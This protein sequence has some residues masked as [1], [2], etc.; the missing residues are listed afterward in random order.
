MKL[1][2]ES[3]I[4]LKSL[5]VEQAKQYVEDYKDAFISKVKYSAPR[6]NPTNFSAY[7]EIISPVNGS[8][9][10]ATLDYCAERLALV[11]ALKHKHHL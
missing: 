1:S 3:E 8:M 4:T 6:S 7:A 10:S 2:K 5:S 9:V 11:A